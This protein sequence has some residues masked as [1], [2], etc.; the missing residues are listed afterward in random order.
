MGDA[1]Q[2]IAGRNK[3]SAP[4]AFNGGCRLK[5][6]SGDVAVPPREELLDQQGVVIIVEASGVRQCE[7][8]EKVR[9]SAKQIASYHEETPRGEQAARKRWRQAGTECSL[10]KAKLGR[11]RWRSHT[12]LADS[13][14]ERLASSSTGWAGA[15][16]IRCTFLLSPSQHGSSFTE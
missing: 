10:A 3:R 9:R 11:I 13:L 16:S 5:I 2:F 15:S 1:A 6:R 14:F 4:V 12:G 8:I 7:E